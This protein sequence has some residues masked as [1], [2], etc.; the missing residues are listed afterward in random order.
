MIIMSAGLK[1]DIGHP[2]VTPEMA[3]SF[4]RERFENH[5][6]RITRH[7]LQPGDRVIEMGTCTGFVAMVAASIVGAENI[8]SF[9]ANPVA[10]GLA[11]HHFELNGLPIKL[12]NKVLL[13]RSMTS[14][15]TK[16][17]P[18][19]VGDQLNNNSLKKKR[20]EAIEVE[21]QVLEDVV[22]EF[23][24]NVLVMDVEGAEIDILCNADL[25][26]IDHIVMETHYRK[27]GRDKTD[28]MIR[29]LYMKGFCID[30]QTCQAGVIHVDRLGKSRQ[31]L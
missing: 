16:T 19:Y 8:M 22:A 9:E 5:E 3:E 2:L 6:A 7:V 12:T 26:G 13:P 10:A 21:I 14:P 31:K 28:R 30:L 27:M 4:R 25:D 24:A 17:I 1:I 23:Q 18:F 29:N 15:G 11:R 20:G